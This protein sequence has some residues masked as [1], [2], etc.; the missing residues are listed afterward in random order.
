MGKP[1][2][3]FP[4]LRSQGKAS[5][6]GFVLVVLLSVAAVGTAGK[7]GDLIGNS[8]NIGVEHMQ[9]LSLSFDIGTLAGVAVVDVVSESKETIYLDVPSD[10]KQ[11]EVRNVPINDV[12][13]DPVS[14]GYV[15]WKLPAGA[16]VSFRAPTD[17]GRII[18]HN[19]SGISV[20][21]SVRRANLDTGAVDNNVVLILKGEGEL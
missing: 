18:L 2:R 19:P 9:P 10:W 13:A 7:T 11:R 8:T 17:P 14:F 12:T 4:N 15:R 16:G 20:K 6:V 1:R 21:A 5:A 3:S